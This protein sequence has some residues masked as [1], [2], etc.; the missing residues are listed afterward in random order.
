MGKKHRQK[1]EE[2]GIEGTHV[3]HRE[4]LK[5]AKEMFHDI[6]DAKNL[7]IANRTRAKFMP[8]WM[9]ECGVDDWH[10][11]DYTNPQIHLEFILCDPA[12]LKDLQKEGGRDRLF[13]MLTDEEKDVYLNKTDDKGAKYTDLEGKQG[14]TKANIVKAVTQYRKVKKM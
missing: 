1:L 4:W 12:I 7:E 2:S 13:L 8:R 11:I 6:D 10:D 3:S 9:E 14:F 5:R